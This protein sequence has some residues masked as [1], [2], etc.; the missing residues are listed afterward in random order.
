MNA[1]SLQFVAFG[2]LAACVYNLFR[3][4]AWR[5]WTLLTA[6]VLLLATFARSIYAFLPFFAFLLLGYLG[7]RVLQ[8][9]LRGKAFVPLL[10]LVMVTFVWLKR[11]AF[12]PSA[13]FLSFSYVTVGMSYVLFR[14]LHMMIDAH[15]NLLPANVGAL[16]YLNYTLNFMTLVSGPIQKYEDFANQHLASLR[17][18]L[19]IFKLGEGIH[20]IIVGFFKVSV[21]S[22]LL[23]MLQKDALAALPASPFNGSDVLTASIVAVSYPLYLYFNF[24]GYM[25]IVIG[26]GRFFRF[27]LPENFDRP[28]SSDNFISF[29]SRWHITLSAWLKTYVFNP[30]LLTSMRR[31]S[32]PA[33]DPFLAVPA[34]F[35][36]FFIVGVWHGQ[37]SEFLV[38]GFLQGFGVAINQLYQILLE[39][40]F[41]REWYKTLARNPIYVAASRGLTFTWFT[42]T[43]FWFWSNWKQMA[44]LT[45]TMGIQGVVFAFL[46]I[47]LVATTSLNL[48]EALRA[49]ALRITWNGSPVLLS[50]YALTVLDTSL[51]VVVLMVV[52]LLN[53]PAPDIVYKAF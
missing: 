8:S 30:L 51:A 40:Q 37:T 18:P 43:L 35:V 36:T 47:F 7:V 29:W 34:L 27:T 45:H 49:W 39:K 23:S 26:I 9:E 38:F 48:L 1:A 19:T 5:Q 25:D 10:L 31:N 3:S 42:F 52:M 11:Y 14:I 32:I 15:A 22:A 12:L 46:L 16:S 41:G 33:L 4:L 28:F 6:N 53:A 2:V 21:L 24:S 13:S 44:E 50:R 17:L 20:R